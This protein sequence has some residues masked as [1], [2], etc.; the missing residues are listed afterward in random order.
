LKFGV[1]VSTELVSTGLVSTGLVRTGLV[2]TDIL[3]ELDTPLTDP[4]IHIPK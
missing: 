1:V 4:Q 3:M 2:N